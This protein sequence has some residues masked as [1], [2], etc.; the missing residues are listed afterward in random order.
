MSR[1]NDPKILWSNYH[2][3]L[4]QQFELKKSFADF[5]FIAQTVVLFGSIEVCDEV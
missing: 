1:T 4:W 3:R 2:L 5:D